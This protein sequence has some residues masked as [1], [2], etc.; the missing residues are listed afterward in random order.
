MAPVTRYARSGDVSVAYQVHGDG[1]VDLVYVPGAFTHLEHSWTNPALAR[2]SERLA[3]F[4]RL[5][6]I[7]KRGTGM[8]DRAVEVSTLED[9]MDDVRAVMDAAGS[10]RAAIYGVSEGGPMAALF[11]ATHPDRTAALILYGTFPRV[12]AA[13]DW[14]GIP[15]EDWAASIEESVARFGHGPPLDVWAP[16]VAHDAG[17]REWWG[18]HQRMS[19][20]PGA[21]RTHMRMQ[22]E[23]DVRSVLPT[24]QC[25]TLV[26]HRKDDRVVPIAAGRYLAAR[27]PGAT[28]VELEGA[29]HLPYG[30]MEPAFGAVEEFLTGAR[31]PPPPDRVLA[32]IVFTDVVGSTSLAA[33][34]GDRDWRELLDRHDDVVRRAAGE[35]C[36]RVVKGTGDGVLA[37]FDGPARA[38]RFASDVSRQLRDIGLEVRAGVHTGEVEVRGPDIAGIAVHIAARIAAVA[39]EREIL[40]SRTVKDLTAGAGFVFVDRGVHALKGVPDDWQIYAVAT[41]EGGPSGVSAPRTGRE[42]RA[43]HG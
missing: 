16:S 43:G 40:T 2:Q 20:S 25:P 23:I 8:S 22:A 31:H 37:T 39:T 27:I 17:E 5:I 33:A 13:P 7:D 42:G 38:V 12:L 15:P 41:A 21:V 11:A 24:I 36:G 1:P 3:S 6:R 19:S 32:T 28:L 4:S 14:P 35:Y 34:R 10:R 29:D 18:T 30:D 9:R 26:L